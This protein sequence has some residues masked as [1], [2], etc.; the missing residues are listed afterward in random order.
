MTPPARSDAREK[1]GAPVTDALPLSS[2]QERMRFEEQIRPGSTAYH[3]SEIFRVSGLLDTAAL[4][5]AVDTLVSR[6]AALRTVFSDLADRS[7]TPTQRVLPPGAVRV[8][9][10]M[11]ATDP[12][13]AREAAV[14]EAKRPF[15][16]ARGP[17]LRVLVIRTGRAEQLLVLTLHHLICD[18]WSQSILHQELGAAYAASRAGVKPDL[19][20]LRRQFPD[21]VRAERERL[22]RQ[23]A[24]QLVGWW[25]G[26][27]GDA[28]TVLDLPAD[29][30]RAAGA[31]R[32]SARCGLL[33]DP[34]RSGAVRALGR[35]HGATL[36]MTL[37]SALG[38]V[39][40]RQ[41]GQERLLVGSPVSTRRAADRGVVGCFLNTLPLCLDVEGDPT[42]G[43]FLGRVR[44]SVLDALAHQDVP[45]HR[46]AAGRGA[47]R[48]PDRAA[49]IQVFFNV[50][51]PYRELDLAD[52]VTERQALPDIDAKFDLSLYVA[53][54]G[55]QLALDAVYDAALYQGERV[56][57]LLGQLT[58][59]LDQAVAD[60]RRRVGAFAL[61]TGQAAQLT[62][63]ARPELSALAPVPP[64]PA[65]PGSLLERLDE[66]A[67][68]RP[69]HPALAGPTSTW[70]YQDLARRVE[71]LAERLAA[72][73]VGRGDVLA[74]RAARDPAVAVAVLAAMRI[75]AVFALLDADHPADELRAA[76]ALL[77]P[78]AWIDAA[79]GHPAG[80]LAPQVIDV[81]GNGPAGAPPA[82]PAFRPPS[83][84]DDAYV[85]FTSGTTG[86]P[87]QIIGTHGPLTHFLIWYTR[88]FSVT[89]ADRFSVLSGI[90][91]DP[92]LRDVLAPLWA[93][94]TAVFPDADVR[95]SAA[96]ALALRR[97]EVTVTHL[98]P[99]LA[100]ALSSAP[101]PGWPALR[102][103]GFGGDVLTRR[104]LREWAELAP[105]ADLLNLYGATETPQ[106]VSVHVARRAGQPMPSGTDRVPLGP[107][108]DE[109]QL[110]VLAGD[111]PAAIGE[112][113]EIVV[114]TR[115][116]ARYADSRSG[117]LAGEY[118]TGDLGRLRPDGLV[119]FAGRADRQVK[120]RGH[121]VE[122]AE[123]EAVLAA[124]PGV[125][126]AAVLAS[127]QER[128]GPR[129][130]ACLAVGAGPRPDLAALRAALSARLASYK[131]PAAF[132]VVDA[133]PLTSN[134]KID[135]ALLLGQEAAVAPYVAPGT[136]L[137]QQL[138]RLWG[139][140]LGRERIGTR[141]DFFALGGH[142]LL[143]GQVRV[144]IR[145]ELG[146]DVTLRELFEHPTIAGLAV[147]VGQSG[148]AAPQRPVP[149]GAQSD[150]APL[151]WTQERIWLEDQ[152]RPGDTAY[153]MPFVLR[154]RGPLDHAALQSAVN[155]VVRRHAVL[156]SRIFVP[157]GGDSEPVQ[158]PRVDTTVTIRHL[159]LT[160]APEAA[161]AEAMREA[162]Q[163]FDLSRGPL[164][165][166]L[167]SRTAADER[168][169]VL[170][171]HHIAFDGWSFSVLL[172]AIS[173]SYRAALRGAPADLGEGLG[174]ADVAR[175]QR[176]EQ[177][178]TAMDRSA[179]WWRERLAGW[180]TVLD[181]PT[182]HSRPPAQAH[183]GAR[184]RLEID[185]ETAGQL[186]RLARSHDTTLFM[187][188]LSAFGAVLSRWAGQ[189]RLLVGTPVASRDRAEFEDLVGCFINTVAVP[190]DL[191]GD[192]RFE[193]LLTRVTDSALSAFAHQAVPL[194][195]LVSDLAQ[196]DLSR[197]PLIQVLFALQNVRISAFEAPGVACELVEIEEANVQ[198]DLNLRMLDMGGAITGWLD[199]DTALFDAET[200]GRLV[201]QLIR[202][203][204]GVTADPAVRVAAVDLLGP[205]ERHALLHEWNATTVPRP[206]GR[207]LTAL[208]E[209][210]A[211]RSPERVAVRCGGMQLTYAELHRRAECLA[212]RLLE[213]GVGPE[214]VVGVH[215]ERS[216]GLMIALLAVLK[217]GG[218]YLPL[219]PEY[220]GERLAF[221]MSDAG[222]PVVL[223]APGS[224]IRQFVNGSVTVLNVTARAS[225]GR[226]RIG[227]PAAGPEHLAYVIYTSGST[228]P[229]KGVQ[230]PH[231]GI[232][233][234]LLW[235]QEAY[236]LRADDVVLQKTPISFDVSVWELFW[237]LLAG[238]RV[239]FAE[240][241][242]HRDPLY[243]A[244]L[245]HQERVT[246]CHFV[247][248]MLHA[249]LD[250]AR[251]DLCG[252]LRLVVSSGEALSAD[253]ARRF[254]RTLPAAALENLYGPTETSVDVTRWSCQADWDRPAVPIGTPIAN[255][256]A[257][258]LDG[259]MAPLPV[260]VPGEL[261]LGGVQLARAYAG[262]PE[263]TA[264]RFVPDP[265]SAP[266]A[267]LYRTGDLARW[268]PD[269]V[270]EYLGRTDRQ[271]KVRGFR[272]EPGEIEAALADQPGVAQAVVTVR[273]DQPGERRIIAYLTAELAT[274]SGVQPASPPQPAMLRA[275]LARTLPDHMI[276]SAFVTLP[277]M[278]LS[279]NGKLDRSALPA[280]PR[281]PAD[282]AATYIAPRTPAER[283]VAAL[284]QEVLG[285][286][287]V[288]V[289][290]NFFELGGD[291]MHAVRVIGLAREQGLD[292]TLA[293][294]FTHQTVEAVAACLAVR[295]EPA[296]PRARPSEVA[297][298]G[299]L[300]PA[301]LAR[302]QAK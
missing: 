9:I 300:S 249:F 223:T 69:G 116:L 212:Q 47:A 44:R 12:G 124:W 14:S 291:S 31:A 276:P 110:L 254:H 11:A 178:N 68:R 281:G 232:A 19:P 293:Q 201:D 117:H 112:L 125:R 196:R 6:H 36:F 102:L 122:P 284:W 203:I 296:E 93:G 173:Q 3:M 119:D 172:D 138:A 166:V 174:F 274:A 298:F 38:L 177:D 103:V 237:P 286:D 302:L 43:E 189:D 118:R 55:G 184:R 162:K 85:A 5:E 16:L 132:I 225:A 295:A 123:V 264:D 15:D 98:T 167:L 150:P 180:P 297:A 58:L 244:Q 169:L 59:A 234:R 27:L 263:L 25:R 158:Q 164:L 87:R 42:F 269:G 113:G 183:R 136:A 292:L 256:R 7:G 86:R 218:A 163:P 51:P 76:E 246:V 288:G 258:V 134:G 33:L 230:V 129:L 247:P 175:W 80:A 13:A 57:D 50:V 22:D 301:D 81:G 240:P 45:F 239:V 73:G 224:D 21:A 271:V 229:P 63:S 185:P 255:T 90:G 257:Y 192:P 8:E 205:A 127:P 115:H 268:R 211:R 74:V 227:R 270:L 30:G 108:I 156:R 135:N 41:A 214:T 54:H 70:S 283:Q 18:G 197:S 29:H 194:G 250:T 160:A 245:I 170:T 285:R 82:L 105:S 279:P 260:G 97:Q 165:R 67:R 161:H 198:F 28:P 39:I 146:A 10:A 252:S 151:S 84:D 133:F 179:T 24:D 79:P 96:L 106:A 155:A 78:A 259:R 65:Q 53:D 75:N 40:A 213:L 111:K 207:T 186:R 206:P 20:P 37:L 141:D 168:L 233:N 139:E 72:R 280:P 49:L 131:V 202:L 195:R 147:L 17:L 145:E 1:D 130:V 159:D 61:A 4:Q 215:L 275:G 226:Q 77:K 278:P 94:A 149:R 137:E 181:L 238:A 199:Y 220:P 64:A 241:G 248:A 107:G 261:Y 262:R 204:R 153:N 176:A 2:T 221:M 143:L 209:E 142:S 114:R 140:V 231:Q 23:A 104:T 52:C 152:L 109:V 101:A 242:G 171:V 299:L 216:A 88:A 92:F 290:E 48:E 34:T 182:D 91:H 128:G 187:V 32:R 100:D 95:D 243:L 56:A 273:E 266:G 236:R 144:R 62:R 148:P 208:L 83:P 35:A 99:A 154:L 71:G 219:D 120:V 126:Q 66:H 272:I 267:R 287:R 157:G 265:F 253:L 188:L 217:A 210:Q 26:Y 200:V 277:A 222:V 89:P 228:G 121:R 191:R 46:L 190:V 193:E 289:T 235:M 282:P 60:P 251:A 294:L